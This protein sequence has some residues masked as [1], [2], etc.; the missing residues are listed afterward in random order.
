MRTALLSAV[1]LM[2]VM[3]PVANAYE[4]TRPGIDWK[5]PFTPKDVA[6]K[7]A[8]TDPPTF[9]IVLKRSSPPYAHIVAVNVDGTLLKTRIHPRKGGFPVGANFRL[10][11]VESRGSKVL[12]ESREFS[13][14]H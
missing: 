9:D 6:W 13:I 7:R 11:F 4:V 2:F 12:A 5:G 14:R 3:T 8:A 1:L 10:Q